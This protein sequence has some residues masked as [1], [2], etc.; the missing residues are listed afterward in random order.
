V[1]Q[2]WGR[3]TAAMGLLEQVRGGGGRGA[4]RGKGKMDG[5]SGLGKGLLEG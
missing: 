3:A 5:G 4:G 2:V 1:L